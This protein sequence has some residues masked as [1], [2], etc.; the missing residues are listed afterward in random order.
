MK[1]SPPG[2]SLMVTTFS[3]P[4]L[5][6]L[7]PLALAF[8]LSAPVIFS[9][10]M[11]PTGSLMVY[12]DSLLLHQPLDPYVLLCHCPSV[13]MNVFVAWVCWEDFEQGAWCSQIC[14]SITHFPISTCVICE[15]N[16][17]PQTIR[18][19]VLAF[20]WLS[21]GKQHASMSTVWVCESLK[22]RVC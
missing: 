15:Q 12:P 5:G 16:D 17:C 2:H 22:K 14:V 9:Q 3:A 6:Y 20:P 1:T 13:S 8:S 11:S 18:K 4:N 10:V 21:K 19:N 7:V